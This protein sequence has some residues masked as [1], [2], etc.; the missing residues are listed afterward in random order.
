[1]HECWPALLPCLVAG[2][3][4]ATFRLVLADLLH[5]L[6]QLGLDAGSLAGIGWA[7]AAFL[8][9]RLRV[10]RLQ[11]AHRRAPLAPPSEP[12]LPDTGGGD[13]AQ[14]D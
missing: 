10:E 1:M 7:V 14:C 3:L 12:A 9:L 11:R 6:R 4:S 5:V 2:G 13:T 8:Y